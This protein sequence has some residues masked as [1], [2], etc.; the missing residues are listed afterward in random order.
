MQADLA[1]R[2][3][4]VSIGVLAR[5]TGFSID[6]IRYYERIGLMPKVPRSNGG[7]RLYGPEHVRRLAFVRRS[8]E[9]GMTLRQV[10]DMVGRIAR[11]AHSCE[12][13]RSILLE[14]VEDVRGRLAEL[15]RL[16][17]TVQ[18]AINLCGDAKLPSCRVIEAM[19]AGG[20]MPLGA[21]YCS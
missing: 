18:A 15:Q 13:V 3:G 14:R 6:T 9:L 21:C 20:E 19:L 12:E 17:Q 4:R 11:N 7:Q 10:R 5:R 1:H 2:E 16:E 8:R